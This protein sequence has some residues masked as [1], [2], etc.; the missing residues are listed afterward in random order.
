MYE[1]IFREKLTQFNTDDNYDIDFSIQNA[2]DFLFDLKSLNYNPDLMEI[3]N[4]N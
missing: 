2:I 4:N 3:E 1:E